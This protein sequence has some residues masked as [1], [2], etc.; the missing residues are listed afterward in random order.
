[1]NKKEQARIKC[2]SAISK[3]LGNSKM[4]IQTQMARKLA[5]IKQAMPPMTAMCRCSSVPSQ[6][7][8]SYDCT[9]HRPFGCRLQ[10]NGASNEEQREMY[11][12]R[13]MVPTVRASRLMR[14]VLARWQA[15]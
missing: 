8:S 1:M 4:M 11:K 9:V 2:T 6:R 5:G 13:N 15:R 10:R 14:K 3:R 12:T 7:T